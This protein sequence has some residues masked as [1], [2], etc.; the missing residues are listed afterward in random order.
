MARGR[1]VA[2]V[3]SDGERV[4]L[5]RRVRRRKS[6]H[7]AARRARIV[8]LAADGLSNTA[9]AEKLGVSRLTRR[10]LAAALCRA[11]YRRARRRAAARRAAQD[12]RRQD[13]RGGDADAGNGARRCDPLEP[14]LDGPG[15][16]HLGDDGAPHLGR[17]R[18]AAAPLGDLQA[19]ERS[20]VHRQGARHHR[21]LSR[22]SRARAGALCRREE[23][24][25]GARPQPADAAHA[26]PAR[27]SAAATTT[28][29]T[30]R[31]RCSPRS[32]WRRVRSS[33]VA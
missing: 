20:A 18:P 3:L 21:P 25:P 7:G 31:P 33:A 2:I 29:G 17:L 27:R 24:D 12:R 26:A 8:L 11:G 19:V 13:R 10:H 22:P 32:T 28:S 14:P 30:A 23:P 9:I 15:E 5:D 1:A 6:S 4:E 16:R